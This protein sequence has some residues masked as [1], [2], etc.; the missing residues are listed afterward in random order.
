MS[1]NYNFLWLK[2]VV[3]KQKKKAVL[4]EV[5]VMVRHMTVLPTATSHSLVEMQE[6]FL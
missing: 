6:C 4:I 2:H 1:P 5:C 3:Y